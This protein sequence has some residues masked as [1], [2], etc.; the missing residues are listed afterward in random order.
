MITAHEWYREYHCNLKA[1]QARNYEMDS[2]EAEAVDEKIY[3]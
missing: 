2:P 1:R 3:E